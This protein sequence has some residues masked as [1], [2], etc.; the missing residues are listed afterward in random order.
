[1][2]AGGAHCDRVARHF[3]VGAEYRL[4]PFKG[5]Y[6]KLRKDASFPV[7]GNIYPVPDVRNP[8]LGVHF[9]RSV[10]GDVYVGP[11]AIPAFGRENYGLF[12]G[13]DC[14]ALGNHGLGRAALLR[15]CR[16]PERR[17]LRTAQVRA[18][19][20]PSRRSAAGEALRPGL[21]ERAAKVGIRPQLVDWRTKELVM[22]FLVVAKDETV[23]VLNPHLARVHELDGPRPPRGGGALRGL[24]GDRPARRRCGADPLD[25]TNVRYLGC[26]TMI[27]DHAAKP[28]VR[29]ALLAALLAVAA[30]SPGRASAAQTIKLGVENGPHADMAEIVKGLLARD[31]IEVKV[32]ELADYARQNPALAAGD[33]DANSFQHQ[34]YLDEQVKDRGYKLVAV[35]KTV[36][37]HGRVLSQ[38][39]VARR[40][41][42]GAKIALPN[43]PSNGGRAL[44]LL[45]SK[46][47]LKV[48]AGAGI[49]PTAADVVEN[50]R[51]VKIVE[52]DASQVAHFLPD[53][54]AAVINTNYALQGKLDPAKDAI[55]R[56]SADSPYVNVIVVRQADAQK[57]WV[58]KLVQAY[59]SDEVRKYIARFPGVVVPGF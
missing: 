59:H 7:K 53:V 40:P 37:S 5:I 33:L 12:G 4:I 8:F 34:P 32:V 23:H 30:S 39:E 26:A 58:Q 24:S 10:H 16:V 49:T 25:G 19:L 22:D 56:E 45:Q 1:M 20:L 48:R 35:G 28:T 11:T 15:Q 17:P 13:M 54:E 2:N 29:R 6:R 44:L 3:G 38:A 43:D 21:F 18:R 47:I 51:K 31:G 55:A 41:A 50:P 42:P 14:E 52:V 46:G 9:T 36:V 27:A 57:P